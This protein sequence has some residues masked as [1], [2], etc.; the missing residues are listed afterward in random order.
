MC[1]QYCKTLS[2]YLPL[3]ALFSMGVASLMV[4]ALWLCSMNSILPQKRFTVFIQ[5][6]AAVLIKFFVIRVR[7]LFE[8][9]VYL[10]F[11]SFLANNRMVTG[12]LKFKKREHVVV[13][14][15]KSFSIYYNIVTIKENN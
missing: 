5:K 10:I 7:R 6:N 13:L 2:L 8:G 11:N 4:C 9:G 15:Q 14:S 12:H 1:I 3:N